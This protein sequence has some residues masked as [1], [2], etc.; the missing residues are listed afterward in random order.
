MTTDFPGWV[1]ALL[2]LAVAGDIILNLMLHY[3]LAKLKGEGK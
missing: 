3:E 2:L 1:F